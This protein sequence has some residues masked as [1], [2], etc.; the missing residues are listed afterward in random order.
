M[1]TQTY[2]IGALNR[3]VFRALFKKH[4]VSGEI[5]AFEE[6]WG[7]LDSTFYVKAT[8]KFHNALIEAIRNL[9]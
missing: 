8:E 3:K 6:S 5:E 7:L 1:I 2:T 4:K 9:R